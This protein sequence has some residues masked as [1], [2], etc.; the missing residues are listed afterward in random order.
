VDRALGAADFA[1]PETVKDPE[2]FLGPC[3]FGIEDF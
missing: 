3:G 2:R 1:V